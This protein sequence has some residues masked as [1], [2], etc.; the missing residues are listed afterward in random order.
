METPEDT[1]PCQHPG[2]INVGKPRFRTRRARATRK[3]FLCDDCFA[4]LLACHLDELF[5][6]F[7]APVSIAERRN[8]VQKLK[9]LPD[10][11][12]GPQGR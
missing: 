7:G 10:G 5:L 9:K 1:T 11:L 2:C 3:L 6:Q 4:G 12:G 8:P